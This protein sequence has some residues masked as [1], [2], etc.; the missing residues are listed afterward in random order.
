MRE[1][2]V[3]AEKNPLGYAPVA[4][5]IRKFAI[6]AIIS[7]LVNTIYN[8]TDQVFIGN[9]VG[10]LGSGAT[11]AAFPVVTLSTALAQLIGIGTAAN[12]NMHMGADEQDEASRYIGTGLVLSALAGMCLG[13]FVFALKGPVLL[14]CGA[15]ENV[16]P[17]AR[18][19][20]GITALGLPFLLF[21]SANNMLI[22]AD[23]RPT[24]SMACTVVGA[25]LN[26]CLDALFM[27]VLHWGIRGAAL[28]TVIG[29]VVSFMLCLRYFR[30]FRSFPIRRD[31][32]RLRLR[33]TIGIAKLGLSNFL[34]QLIMM[35][36]NIVLNNTLTHYGAVTVYGCDIPL[37]VSGVVAKLNSVLTAFTVGLA[38]GCQPIFSFNMGA[39]NYGRMK[40]TYRKAIVAALSVSMLVFFVFQLFPRQ[41]TSIFGGNSELYFQFAERYLRIYLMM[42]G[43]GGVQPLTVNYFTAIG[44]VKKGILLSLARQGAFLLPLLIVL[45]L[46]FGLD[47]ALYAGPIAEVL[48]FA[49]SMAVMRRHLRQLGDNK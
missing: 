44:D 17:L 24:Y 1:N 13:A 38:Q 18:E 29:Q 46:Y 48:A 37:A 11:N 7:I 35:I 22:R 31:M 15:T 34:N 20:L 6:P 2:A 19:Y 27:L 21:T 25:G 39:K 43:I 10:I 12:F 23:G 9:T 47:G 45:P 41:V 3:G 42:V 4:G 16:F 28:A 32:L 49:L 5:L 8:I 30:G 40:E 33:E 36:V 14:L 26:V